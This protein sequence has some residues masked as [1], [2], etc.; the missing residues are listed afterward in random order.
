MK[1]R[2]QLVKGVYHLLKREHNVVF[3]KDNFKYKMFIVNV[4]NQIFIRWRCKQKAK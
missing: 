3:R 4:L 1:F 2:A